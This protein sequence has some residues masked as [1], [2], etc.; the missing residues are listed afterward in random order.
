MWSNSIPNF[1]N[2]WG[3]E[4][5]VFLLQKLR[6]P[7]AYLWTF[8]LTFNQENLEKKTVKGKDCFSSNF[9]LDEI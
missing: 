8:K 7:G 3:P 9:Y 5:Y 1:K 6:P 2:F 4:G